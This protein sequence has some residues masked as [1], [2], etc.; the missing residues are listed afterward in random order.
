MN[1]IERKDRDE[2]FQLIYDKDEE[3]RMERLKKGYTINLAVTI[4][5]AVILFTLWLAI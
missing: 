1:N 4:L 3:R 5:V 2:I